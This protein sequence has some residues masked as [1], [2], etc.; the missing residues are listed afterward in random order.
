MDDSARKQWQ[1]PEYERAYH[2]A[3]HDRLIRDEL[4]YELKARQ[5]KESLFQSVP[6]DAS[7]FEFGVGL[8]KNIALLKNKAG[9]DISGFAREFSRRK[10]IHVFDRIEEVPNEHYDVVLSSHVLE[11]LENPFE[12]LNLLSSKLKPGGQLI[13]VLPTERHGVVPFA[14]DADQHLY[15]WNF[16]TINNLLQRA[17]FEIR[18]NRFRYGTAQYK[19]RYLGKLSFS[20]YDLNTRILGKLLSRRDMIVI[21]QKKR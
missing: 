13:L 1:E 16:R 17:G 12:N 15:S 19:L 20:V 7:V 4:Y 3:K 21:A 6:E 18:E 11:H 2:E 14:I 8:G 10:G 9:F 5:A